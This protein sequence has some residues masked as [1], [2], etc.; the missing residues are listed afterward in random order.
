[1]QLY[2]L[3]HDEN[4]GTETCWKNFSKM[5]EAEQYMKDVNELNG[6]RAE[7]KVVGAKHNANV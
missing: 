6:V 2:V 4:L 7:L 5:K 1:M 3:I